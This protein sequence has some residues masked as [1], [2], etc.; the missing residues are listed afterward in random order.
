[1]QFINYFSLYNSFYY[2][3]LTV[4]SVTTILRYLAVQFQEEQGL[5]LLADNH[6][7]ND[8]LS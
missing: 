6:C 2:F 1:L 7:L 5:D 3:I 8:L 4:F